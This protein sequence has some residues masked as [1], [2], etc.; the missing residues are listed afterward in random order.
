[1]S[2]APEDVVRRLDEATLSE[3]LSG[4][5]ARSSGSTIRVEQDVH[6]L[7]DALAR[8]RPVMIVIDDS[9]QIDAASA[10]CL[11]YVMRRL[12][13]TPVSLVATTTTAAPH[14]N[15]QFHIEMLRL[16]GARS[17]SI[18][19]LS[20][21]GVRQ[22]LAERLG[23][24]HADRAAA[25]FLTACG[26]SPLLLRAL[27]DDTAEALDIRDEQVDCVAGE[28]FDRA[29][30]N[31]LHRHP[32]EATRLASGIAM[33]GDSGTPVVLAQLLAAEPSVIS[34]LGAALTSAGLLA[35]SR[36]R[37]PRA[38]EAVLNALPARERS[39]LHRRAA[40]LL[41]EHGATPKVIA[42]HL[43]AADPPR[44]GWV[45]DVLQEAARRAL[46]EDEIPFARECLRVAI[47]ASSDH[48]RVAATQAMLLEIEW[49]SAPSPSGL[50]EDKLTEA[51]QQGQL[52]LGHA[53]TL[54]R[55]LIW[56]GRYLRAADTL[57]AISASTTGAEI[58]PDQAAE[59]RIMRDWLA[60]SHPPLSAYLAPFPEPGPERHGQI[61]PDVEARLKVTSALADVLANRGDRGT[62]SVAK[63]VLQSCR[64][65]DTTV[66]AIEAALLIL[67]YSDQLT[68]AAAQ[69][70]EV[71][72]EAARR[73]APT[74]QAKFGALRGAVHL[75]Q[76]DLV[77]AESCTAE[78]LDRLSLAG[79]G[80]GIG[81]P[82]SV[83]V[84]A[85]LATGNHEEA[86]RLLDIPVPDSLAQSR[87]GLLY[88]FASGGYQLATGRP[89]AA[90]DHFQVCAHLAAEW[91]LDLPT[92][93]PWRSGSALAWL[94][95]GRREVARR[96]LEEQLARVDGSHLS[97]RGHTLR[98]L[99]GTLDVTKRQKVL[100]EAIELQQRVGNRLELAHA[101]ADI[102][103]AH[104]ACGE[105][106]RARMQV[107][108]AQHV[109]NEC[110]AALT[111]AEPEQLPAPDP[112]QAACLTKA[113]KRIAIL[114]A[115]G[116]T[117]RE[118]A[119]QLFITASTVEQHLTRVF[120]KL[121]ITR[122]EEL[123]ASLGLQRADATRDLITVAS[124]ALSS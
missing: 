38:A 37:H 86:R 89:E 117:N 4:G 116:N 119:G 32:A 123:P 5:A 56:H 106:R 64:L 110:G 43:I 49:R 34:S 92:L 80:V 18:G 112:K 67:V 21:R 102:S 115:S 114:A 44:V 107:R 88:R 68:T 78:A 93:V 10:G 98:L 74:W 30:L 84:H 28:A 85:A 58:T 55:F 100:T 63:H 41:H 16:P 46:A 113:E 9:H 76:G 40:R 50:P 31:C 24:E 60:C 7:L 26:G 11:L 35:E 111:S 71:C 1:M 62:V 79:W 103:V 69:C 27:V 20:E 75:R 73:Q 52:D 22:I 77:R 33:L 19:P 99:A 8:R 23:S 65:S 96:L 90:L 12:R 57:R 59:L 36:F 121:T 2:Y 108:L 51:V 94:R 70:E 81:L 15:T 91:H 54:A 39:E 53:L 14:V 83:L 66:E 95:L 29:V 25:T 120:R 72:A 82:L 6:T 42:R 122:R 17:V 101:L 13:A 3:M 109:A 45:V 97:T 104:G 105:A 48:R 118:I 124:P 47:W 87:Y 61:L